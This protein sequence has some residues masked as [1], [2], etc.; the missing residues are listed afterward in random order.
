MS[1]KNQISK[2]K[3]SNGLLGDI[4]RMI[5]ESRFSVAVSVNAALTILYWRIGKR[6]NTEILKGERADYGKEILATLSQQLTQ[7]YG[8]GFSYSALTRMVK[9]ADAFPETQIVATL[10]Q[11][12]SWSHFR[13]LLPLDKPL[14]RDFYAE[15]CRVEGWSVRTL[16]Q[17]IDSMLYE[18]TALSKKPEELAK[19]ELKELRTEDKLVP[20]LVFRDPY[21][22][23]FL[24]L[25]D[26]YLEKDLEDAILREMESFLLELGAG[27]AFLARQKRIQIDSDDFYIDLLLFNRKLKRLIAIDLKLGDFKAEYKGQMELYLR[28]L[29]KYERQ[30]GEE[31]PLGIILCAG[32]KHEQIKLLELN[33]S[34]IHVAEYLT[35]L[36]PREMLQEK[37]HQAIELSRERLSGGHNE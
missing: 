10:S 33:Q 5:E 6:I 18:R 15:M 25:K 34:G 31:P 9:F 22:L 30:P 36:P 11:T 21:I 26:R 4:R 2:N 35:V 27:F 14:Q 28:W 3:S 16:R 19:A 37:L 20:D 13:E 17:K 8:N 12:L 23:D 29:D 1:R 24:G 32:K 7:E